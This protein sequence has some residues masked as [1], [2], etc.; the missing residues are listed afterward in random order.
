MKKN[1][2]YP[3]DLTDR[4]WDCLKELIPPAKPGGRPRTLEMRGVINAIL[5]LVVT[6]CQ[7]RLLPR[8]FPAWQSVSTYFRQWC[9]DGTWQ[10][11]HDTLRAQVRW[12]AGRHKHPTTGALDRE[13][14][15][16]DADSWRAWLRCGQ[17][18]QGAQ[19]SYPGGDPRLAAD[20]PGHLIH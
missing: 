7:W 6:G 13:T 14:C 12:Q 3:S 20:R 10:R 2:L 4:Q 17:E 18:G 1:Q 11:I 19:T 5:Y 9:D 15:Q 8:E 16:D